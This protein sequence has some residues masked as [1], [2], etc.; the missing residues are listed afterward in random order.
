M[1]KSNASRA[2][3]SAPEAEATPHVITFLA[4]IPMVDAMATAVKRRDTD[5]SKW[6]R[7]AIREKAAR[8][9]VRITI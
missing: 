2:T 6:L 1:S 3:G 8:E 9:G 5:R 7:E 4:P